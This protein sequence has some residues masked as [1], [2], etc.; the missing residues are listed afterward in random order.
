M[1]FVSVCSA[2]VVSICELEA[3]WGNL[4]YFQSGQRNKME[5]YSKRSDPNIKYHWIPFL[6]G[7]ECT[8]QCSV[9]YAV[10]EIIGMDTESRFLLV[11]FQCYS[12]YFLYNINIGVG[13]FILL[14]LFQM[15][16]FCTVGWPFSGFW[17]KIIEIFY[18]VCVK[19]WFSPNSQ[20]NLFAS[21]VSGGENNSLRIIATYFTL[22]Q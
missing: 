3:I 11:L 15:L 16:K 18:L 21:E 10:S 1:W 20:S 22:I 13:P 6:C 2:A 9:D 7:P 19:Y 14:Y 12:S 8:A 4:S 5:H 17:N